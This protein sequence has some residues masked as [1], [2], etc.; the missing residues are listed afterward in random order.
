MRARAA[1]SVGD[2]LPLDLTNLVAPYGRDRRLSLRVERMPG[3]SRL[4]RGRNNGDGSWSLTRD[5]LEGLFYFPPRGSNDVPTLV[6]RVVGLDS[7][8]GATLEVVDA[9]PGSSEDDDAADSPAPPLEVEF[10]NL[11]AELAKTKAA[12]RATQANLTEARK[13]FEAELEERLAEAQAEAEAQN[14][15]EIEKA[16]AKWQSDA[17]DRAAKHDT[18]AEERFAH[19]R[20]NWRHEAEAEIARAEE[21]WKAGERAR[22][23]AA[24]AQWREQS[25]R[26]IASEKTAHSKTQAALV[27]AQKSAASARMEEASARRLSEQVDRLEHALGE[28]DAKIAEAQSAASAAQEK[29]ERTI[30][31]TARERREFASKV[32]QIEARLAEAKTSRERGDTAEMKR[33]RAELAATE[34]TVAA[35]DR[36]LAEMRDDVAAADQRARELQSALE[37]ARE[38]GTETDAARERR[39]VAETRKLRAELEA[40]EAM[41]SERDRVLAEIKSDASDARKREAELRAALANAETSWRSSEASRLA[42]Q[43]SKW[44]AEWREEWQERIAALE[45]KLRKSDAALQEARAHSK[46]ARDRRDTGDTRRLTEEISTLRAKLDGRDRELAAAAAEADKLRESARQQTDAALANARKE[47]ETAESA[48]FA[49]AKA[50]WERHSSRVFKKAQIR[51]EAAEA[52]LAEARA[53]ASAARD[54]RDSAEFK[55]LRAEFAAASTKLA[56]SE[57][58]LAEAQLA[59]ARA[60]ERTREEVEAAVAKAEE[61]WKASEALRESEIETRERER[62]ARALA[63]AMAR[64]ERTEAALADAR[65]ELESERERAAVQLAEA[66]ARLERN[67]TA[68]TEATERIETMR[69]PANESELRRLRNE[70]ANLQVAYTDREAELTVIQTTMRKARERS[71]DQ[72]RAAVLKAEDEWRREEAKRLEAAKLNWERQAQFAAE[73]NAAPEGVSEATTTKRANRLLLDTAL[74]IGLAVVVVLGFTFYWRTPVAGVPNASAA[75]PPKPVHLAVSAPAQAAGVPMTIGTAVAR[76]R[77]EPD[78]K[79]ATLSTLRRGVQVSLLERRGNWARVHLD[80]SA[81]KPARDGWI[82][83][84]SLRAAAKP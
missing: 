5:E 71:A 18:R 10:A 46:T 28:R 4:S 41:L 63:E 33:L 79:G 6:V 48:R 24:E 3:R 22:L 44:D 23:A 15:A 34:A 27:A 32:Q 80:S 35:R 70:L 76:L 43:K 78:M 19:A 77:A 67:E 20:E 75:L 2:G 49:D 51:L 81:G 17:K 58:Q 16:R 66:R 38:K 83:A 72:T 69:D 84:A 62:G 7:D 47:W 52:A 74:A 30:E 40:A 53:E 42:V 45:D 36:E 8:N 12:L 11:K 60:R 9:V 21:A 56:D 1:A 37:K 14:A 29:L 73:M 64:L 57:A 55:R 13:T 61:A 50:E 25:A 59:A 26:A 39:H 68:L 82:F 54:R 31:E 65:N